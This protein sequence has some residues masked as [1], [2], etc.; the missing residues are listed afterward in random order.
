MP[1]YGIYLAQQDDYVGFGVS[2]KVEGT[3]LC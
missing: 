1:F 3:A 2:T